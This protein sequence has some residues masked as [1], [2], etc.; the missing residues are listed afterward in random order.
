MSV[1]TNYVRDVLGRDHG[2]FKLPEG[3]SWP[4]RDNQIAEDAP[5]VAELA[6]V[7]VDCAVK[8]LGS[9]A[10]WEKPWEGSDAE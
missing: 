3:W 5:I 6:G 7:H 8:V 9:L 4:E 2:N 10:G 1:T